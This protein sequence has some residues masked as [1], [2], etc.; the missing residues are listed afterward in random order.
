M[1]S[2]LW[3]PPDTELPRVPTWP[4]R[5]RAGDLVL[6]PLRRR[7]RAEWD[8]V[9]SRN[10]AWLREWDATTPP[11]SA[12]PMTFQQMVRAQHASGRAFSSVPLV[13]CWGEGLPIIGQITVSSIVWGSAR[14]GHVGYWIDG[15][16][17]GRG[18]MPAAVA[19]VSSYCFRVLGLHRLEINIRPENAASL[20]VVEKLGFRPEGLRPR[21]L[22]IN[23]AWRDHLSFALTA[24]EVLADFV[25]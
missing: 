5:L 19:L 20:R 17:A 18:L 22:H 21:Y 15:R 10:A 4:L 1:K 11:G 24:D 25:G 13:L 8:D 23:G 9:R 12:E 3:L 14:M 2:S 7:D 16:C 6:R